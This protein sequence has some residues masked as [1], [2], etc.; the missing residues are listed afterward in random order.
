MTI[1]KMTTTAQKLG[2]TIGY[3]ETI[4]VFVV[5]L[6]FF[7]IR[8]VFVF[9]IVRICFIFV[10]VFFCLFHNSY[11]FLKIDR[12]WSL[13]VFFRVFHNLMKC[14]PSQHRLS[15]GSQTYAYMPVCTF[16]R[17]HTYALK[18][19]RK[20]ASMHACTHMHVCTGQRRSHTIASHHQYT[21][22]NHLHIMH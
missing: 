22:K 16:A 14:N 20:R 10:F 6:M 15:W 17:M 19:G 2:Q 8:M 11:F 4:I 5:V 21:H 13:F 7:I 3:E 9:F 12:F 1:M 18:Y